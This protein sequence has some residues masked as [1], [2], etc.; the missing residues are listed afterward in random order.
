MKPIVNVHEL[1]R[2]H[3]GRRRYVY[4]DATG[5][6]LRPGDILKGNP[7][8]G[9]GHNLEAGPLPEEVINLLQGEDMLTAAH[10]VAVTLGK[11]TPPVDS[12]RWAALV[13]MVFTL[14]VNRFQKFVRMLSAI[15]NQNWDAASD[16]LM[17]SKWAKEEAYHRASRDADML[18]KDLWPLV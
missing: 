9:V 11:D 2:L 13:D 16:E 8:I 1:I 10:G 4:D 5:E 3:E 15:R 12:A 18:E 17:N 14:G 7:T 6:R